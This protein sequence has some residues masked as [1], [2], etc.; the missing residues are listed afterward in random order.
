MTTPRRCGDSGGRRKDGQ[1]CGMNV[2]D[3]VLLC[4][5]HDP[6]MADEMQRRRA[7]GN[8]SRSRLATTA[9][10]AAERGVPLQPDTLEENA[11]Y[12]A[13]VLDE[14]ANGRLDARVAHE[15]FVG[16]RQHQSVI[17]KRDLLREITTLRK[18]LADARQETP[19]PVLG[20][21]R[22]SHA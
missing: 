7:K 21:H 20:L 13:W 12:T 6:A 8:V 3:G 14:T 4:P 5:M 11:S 10:A 15:L 16:L 17:E 19:K 1:P 9:K 22:G 2:P 18:E